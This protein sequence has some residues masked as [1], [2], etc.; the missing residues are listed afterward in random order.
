MSLM[1]CAMRY[2]DGR[3]SLQVRNVHIS[4]LTR[5]GKSARKDVRTRQLLKRPVPS[6]SD[7]RS[8]SKL[9]SPLQ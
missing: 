1:V 6:S 5:F 4:V 9:A 7:E 8:P 3:S 2:T